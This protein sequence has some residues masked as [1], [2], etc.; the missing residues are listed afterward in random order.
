MPPKSVVLEVPEH[1]LVAGQ[2]VV[3]YAGGVTRRFRL[4]AGVHDGMVVS[5][6]PGGRHEPPLVV[7]LRCRDN[8]LCG[9]VGGVA[10]GGGSAN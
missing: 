5:L 7:L 2:V 3:V 9:G 8:Q 4:P 10:A 1:R 6:P